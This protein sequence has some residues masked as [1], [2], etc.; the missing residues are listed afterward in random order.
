MSPHLVFLKAGFGEVIVGSWSW[1][2]MVLSF[3][4]VYAAVA[5]VTKFRVSEALFGDG[6][7][8]RQNLNRSD[9]W[10][11]NLLKY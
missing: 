2:M 1:L 8:Y 10:T 4:V 6:E 7:R 5:I 9:Y 3:I 11:Y